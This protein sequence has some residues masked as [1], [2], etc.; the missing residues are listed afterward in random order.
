MNDDIDEQNRMLDRWK[1]CHAGF[2][3]K[4]STAPVFRTMEEQLNECRRV[5][6]KIL[7]VAK[8]AVGETDVLEEICQMADVAL[9]RTQPPLKCDTVP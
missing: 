1:E 5:L 8:Y 6:G 3:P 7:S 4:P 2:G 9:A